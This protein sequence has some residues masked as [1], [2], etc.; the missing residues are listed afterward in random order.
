MIEAF[1]VEADLA[2]VDC[3][4]AL[5]ARPAR[6]FPDGQGAIDELFGPNNFAR[7][8]MLERQRVTNGNIEKIIGRHARLRIGLPAC[9]GQQSRQKRCPEHLTNCRGTI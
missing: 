4:L 1:I 9:D 7:R 8:D 5:D 3:D 2:V 6:L